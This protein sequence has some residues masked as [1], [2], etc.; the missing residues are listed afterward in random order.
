MR[1]LNCLKYR[2]NKYILQ[3]KCF[4]RS[5]K[6]LSLISTDLFY[7]QSNSPE[8]YFLIF[9]MGWSDWMISESSLSTITLSWYEAKEKV[10]QTIDQIFY[11]YF[12]F[13]VSFSCFPLSPS[14]LPSLFSLLVAP[15][16]SPCSNFPLLSSFLFFLTEKT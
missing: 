10:S 16:S 8:T 9:E 7:D 5:V 14:L 15:T 13:S 4:S 12:S 3:L 2:L 1:I 6:Q 11:V